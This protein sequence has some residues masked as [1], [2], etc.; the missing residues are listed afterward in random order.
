[1]AAGSSVTARLGWDGT[2]FSAGITKSR[3]EMKALAGDSKETG[4]EMHEAMTRGR[5][6]V[7]L[8]SNEIGLHLDRE[9]RNFLAG[10]PA[11]T[12]ALAGA[13]DIAAVIGIGFALAE[14][15]KRVAEFIKEAKEMPRVIAEGFESLNLSAQ[16]ANDELDVT[17]DKI[18]RQI[19]KLEHKPETNG[20]K[21]ALDEAKVAADQFAKSVETAANAM[22]RLLK[23]N[24][25]SIVQGFFTDTAPTK[26][27]AGTIKPFEDDKKH[28]ATQAAIAKSLGDEKAY[29]L[30]MKDFHDKEESELEKMLAV[31]H[32]AQAKQLEM[33]GVNKVNQEQTPI[34]TTAQSVIDSIQLSR[35]HEQSLKTNTVDKGKLADAEKAA[36]V[37]EEAKRLAAAMKAAQEAIVQQWRESLDQDKANSEVSLAQEAA[38]WQFRAETAK[39]G[40]LSY[41]KALDE[42]NKVI[43]HINAQT[44]QGRKELGKKNDEFDKIAAE[45]Y[46]PDTMDLSRGDTGR[47][48]N[49]ARQDAEYV[50]SLNE[51]IAAQRQAAT[52]VAEQSLE[53]ALAAGQMS[54]LDAAQV[55]ATMHTQDFEQAQERLRAALAAAAL[56]PGEAG[57]TQ[58][59]GLN[60][61]AA[62]MQGQRQ[63]QIASDQQAVSSQQ[64]GP[65]MQQTLGIIANE[66]SSMTKSIIEVTT[67]AMDSFNEDI[68]KMATGQGKR[69][70]FGHTL[71][72]AGQGLFQTALKSFEGNALKAFGLGGTKKA[73]GSKDSPFYTIDTSSGP[74]AG[75]GGLAAQAS[76]LFRP[77]IGGQQQGQG[78]GGG[79]GGFFKTLMGASGMLKLPGNIGTDSFGMPA[80]FQGGFSGGGDIMGGHPA[81]VGENGPELFTP[82]SAGT[83][84]PNGSF[85]GTSHTYMIDARGSND[86]AAIHA[87][88]ARALPHAV[89]ASI[90]ANHAAKA[91][92]PHGR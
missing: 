6:S 61:Q 90:Q 31:F 60:A 56:V 59:A 44:M 34:M 17:N 67:R 68:T 74:G 10:M 19:A 22:E 58:L 21:L 38:Y 81:L 32:D 52:A 35:A 89:A 43:A 55:L 14:S 83:V 7:A 86:P 92:S 69:S 8:L 9:L 26:E 76:S 54:K 25:I 24:Q 57:R 37:R 12:K 53:M 87:A 65:A 50:R 28:L 66:W 75:G 13:F 62:Q 48:E 20:A 30:N 29:A 79:I 2:A 36:Q 88:V 73:D 5:E 3:A 80:G 1:M 51:Q 16:A 63:M 33:V 41:T 85:G 49:Q 27:L 40:S 4:R 64:L 11:V 82:R 72:G 18:E 15:A 78:G 91:R 47:E 77:F 84:S 45:S 46:K 71:L 23:E 42:A 39:T 70:D